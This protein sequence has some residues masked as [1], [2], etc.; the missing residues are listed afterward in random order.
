MGGSPIFKQTLEE[1]SKLE[2]TYFSTILGYKSPSSQHPAPKET[3]D[4]PTKSDA[5]HTGDLSVELF[6]RQD[7]IRTL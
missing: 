6:W 4:S 5:E 3:T 7:T 1:P 2:G